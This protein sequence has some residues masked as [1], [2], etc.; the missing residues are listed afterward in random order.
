MRPAAA[1]E[2]LV[3][4]I[5]PCYNA[6]AFVAETIAS[7]AAQTYPTTEHILVDDGSTD[8]S[9]ATITASGDHI[10]AVRLKQ[11]R[12]GSYARNRGV[13]R[14]RGEFLMFLDADDVLAPEA[15][16]AM[17]ATVR[18]RPGSIAY[19]RWQRLRRSGDQWVTA[20]A[21]VPLPEPGADHLAGWLS[22]MWVPPCALLWR[23]DTYEL[24]G[25]W[26]ESLVANQDGDI[27]MRALV[28]GARL[29]LAAGGPLAWY[30]TH[31]PDRI[32]VSAGT[33]TR[34]WLEAQVRVLDKVAAELGARDA[35]TPYASAIGFTYRHFGR[36]GALHRHPRLAHECLSRAEQ[37]LGP[38]AKSG[39]VLGRLLDVTVGIPR[40]ERLAVMLARAGI[41]SAARRQFV[42]RH[43]GS[44][45]LSR[46]RSGW[47]EV[48]DYAPGE[49]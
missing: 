30:R 31:G 49:M 39:S 6:E 12:G 23:R 42:E 36:L 47:R 38:A 43:Q 41:G 25:D 2:G 40:K 32:T 15:I 17:V 5:T 18:D 10:I 14:A 8:S 37:W 11:N 24:T 9:W 46:E 13:E 44:L 3:S 1:T 33:Y 34:A 20:P 21:E 28:R 22:G 35:G 45:P 7:V 26:D 4:V 27:A 16:A 19:C 29:M 48:R